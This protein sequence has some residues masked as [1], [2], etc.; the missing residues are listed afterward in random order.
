[1]RKSMTGAWECITGYCLY[2]TSSFKKILVLGKLDMH[3][4]NV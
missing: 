2:I 3:K 4:N 1:M